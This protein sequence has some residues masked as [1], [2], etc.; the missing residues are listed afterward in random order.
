[1]QRLFVVF[2]TCRHAQVYA[3]DGDGGP[4]SCV[5]L[6]RLQGQRHPCPSAFPCSVQVYT[7]GATPEGLLQHLQRLQ[8]STSTREQAVAKCMIFNLCDEYRF[9]NKYPEKEL[10]ITAVLFSGLVHL[11]LVQGQQ[12][13]TVLRL[14]LDALRQPPG[15][16]LFDFARETL[17]QAQDSLLAWPHYCSHLLQA[18][19]AQASAAASTRSAWG[20]MHPRKTQGSWSCLAV[21]QLP[22]ACS[23]GCGTC[24]AGWAGAAVT[25]SCLFLVTG[26]NGLDLHAAGAP[27]PRGRASAGRQTGAGSQG[28]LRGPIRGA[29]G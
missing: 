10:H 15:S 12:L 3:F 1:M 24:N 18:S 2:P 16:K 22:H 8:A 17:R 5:R 27:L 7:D 14:V 25:A 29:A 19:S 23:D 20:Y 26:A 9:F 21:F 4:C 28:L 6:L 11:R 13:D